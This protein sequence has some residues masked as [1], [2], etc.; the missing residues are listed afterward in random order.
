[1]PANSASAARVVRAQEFRPRR[2]WEAL[3]L[4]RLD[5]VSA[6]LHWANQPYEWHV[7]DGNEV[8]LVIDGLV[9]MHY[10]CDGKERFVTL[11]TGD[12]FVV[13]AGCEHVARPRGEARVLVVERAKSA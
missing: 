3:E 5:G 13:G 2:A 6:R 7:N 4:M 12:V 8:F 1:M 9:D 11:G 10:R